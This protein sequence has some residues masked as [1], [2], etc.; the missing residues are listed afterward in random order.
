MQVRGLPCESGNAKTVRPNSSPR[1]MKE[2]TPGECRQDYRDRA[3][4]NRRSRVQLSPR[5]RSSGKRPAKT[6]RRTRTEY[7]GECRRDYSHQDA[8]W[9]DGTPDT[10]ARLRDGSHSLFSLVAPANTEV[11]MEG[12]SVGRAAGFGPVG[13]GFEPF[14]SNR[15]YPGGMPGGL[16]LQPVAVCPN[17]CPPDPKSPGE[18]RAALQAVPLVVAGSCPAVRPFAR[19][20]AG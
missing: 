11:L 14:P 1:P 16:Q 5:K 13:R 18:C 20:S 7:R 10:P 3:P 12:S 6:C 17:P 2:I 4:G 15:K 8:I 19:S 9:R